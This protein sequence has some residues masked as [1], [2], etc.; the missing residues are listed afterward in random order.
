MTQSGNLPGSFNES[1]LNACPFLSETLFRPSSRHSERQRSSARK[2]C[3]VGNRPGSNRIARKPRQAPGT[4]YCTGSHAKAIRY[5]CQRSKLEH[6]HPNQLRHNAATAIRKQFGIEGAST[7]LGHSGLEVAQVYAEQDHAKA[8]EI[9]ADP[10]Q[11]MIRTIHWLGINPSV[12]FDP[13]PFIWQSAVAKAKCRIRSARPATG[14]RRYDCIG[15]LPRKLV[16]GVWPTVKLSCIAA[17]VY[18]LCR[19][20]QKIGKLENLAYRR[21]EVCGA[22]LTRVGRTG[23]CWEIDQFS[24]S[25]SPPASR[26]DDFLARRFKVGSWRPSSV[27]TRMP[28]EVLTGVASHSHPSKVFPGARRLLAKSNGRRRIGDSGVV[29]RRIRPQLV[30]SPRFRV[31]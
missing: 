23:G 28:R 2:V 22:T 9:D 24:S 1:A 14:C 11:F 31:G 10:K 21:S 20:L 19:W 7:I 13:P 5:A 17:Q 6:W 18:W 29:Q 16:V 26:S 3:F 30:L 27:R 25:A 12:S 4:S 15:L 8:D